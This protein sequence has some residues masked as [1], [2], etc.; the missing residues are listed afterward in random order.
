M[1]LL[2]KSAKE[3]IAWLE[4]RFPAYQHVGK[5]AYKPNLDRILFLCE[6]LGNPQQ[7][8]RFVHIAGTNGKGT[9][10][11]IL[12][13]ACTEAG[14]RVGMFTSP[15]LLDFSERIRVNGK[16]VDPS[17]ICDFVDRIKQVTFADPPSFFEVS[18]AMA[19]DYFR[20]QGCTLCVIETG[21]GGR[22]DATNIVVPMLSVITNISLDHTAILGDTLTE[23]ATEKAGI[24][25]PK[26]PVVIGELQKETNFVFSTVAKNSQ[27]DIFYSIDYQQGF[28]A[29]D[30]PLIGNHQRENAL[31]AW[32]T[33]QLLRKTGMRI[34]N[35]HFQSG[36]NR[37]SENTGY[38]GRMQVVNETPFVVVDGAHNPAGV[39]H[40]LRAIQ[41]MQTGRLFLIYGASSD[42]DIREVVSYF[43]IDANIS[44]TAFTSP[45][46]MTSDQL[47]QFASQMNK[48]VRVFNGISEAYR[49][50]SQQM[51]EEDTLFIFGSFFLVADFFQFLASNA[52]EK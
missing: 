10:A 40:A 44:F 36:L 41:T 21:L 30:L 4:E 11:S 9:V 49:H 26:V 31:T 50:V 33:V 12:A 37:L 1:S 48:E 5:S 29:I 46:S 52:C 2:N 17:F 7:N 15:H 28:E 13:S 43:P 38:M 27:S 16:V 14:E 35:E 8:V 32:T 19:L 18:F 34:T 6:W 39:Q 42:K 3:Q 20:F 47:G 23:I 51:S 22:L 24:I 25:K 45:R